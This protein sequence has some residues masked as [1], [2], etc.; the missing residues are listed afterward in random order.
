M[1]TDKQVKET[2]TIPNSAKQL[3]AIPK[4]YRAFLDS[5]KAKIRS[6]QVKAA[7]AVNNEL[8]SLYWEIGSAVHKK[9]KEE[10]WGAK[11]I[12]KLA[13]DLKSTIPSM[14]GFSF[15]NIKYM[16]QFAKAYPDF[17]ISQQPVGQIQKKS[18]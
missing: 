5:L 17:L 4:D 13:K 3:D 10:S 2:A 8:I 18:N 16:V 1:T 9:Q 7:V 6:S 12:E 11:T 14:K 15:T